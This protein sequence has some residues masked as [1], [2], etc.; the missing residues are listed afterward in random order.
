MIEMLKKKKQNRTS[1]S[2]QQQLFLNRAAALYAVIFGPLTKALGRLGSL[3]LPAV[4]V[5]AEFAAGVGLL[6]VLG[7]WG[8]V[9]G[10]G[11]TLP[12]EAWAWPAWDRA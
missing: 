11:C 9:S 4:A 3:I 10:L 12:G 2:Q 1:Q 5:A 7:P 6:A 8:I